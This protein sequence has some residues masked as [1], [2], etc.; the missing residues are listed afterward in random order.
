MYRLLLVDVFYLR[1]R[2]KGE[3]QRQDR[4]MIERQ[5]ETSHTESDKEGGKVREIG[6]ELGRKRQIEGKGGR[7][8]QREREGQKRRQRQVYDNELFLFLIFRITFFY[9]FCP[10][11]SIATYSAYTIK[12]AGKNKVCSYDC[13]KRYSLDILTSR[14]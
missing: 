13:F 9:S 7:G 5:K 14:R 10:K 11:V 2:V 8:R 1:V 4:N 6:M 12:E 3:W